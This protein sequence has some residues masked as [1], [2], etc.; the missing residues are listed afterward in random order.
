M[1]AGRRS[2]TFGSQRITQEII[3]GKYVIGW[4][5]GVPLVVLVAIYFF[6]R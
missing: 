6:A 4:F 3:M 5:L 1:Q 2:L